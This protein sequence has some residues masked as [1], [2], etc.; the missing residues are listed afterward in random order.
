MSKLSE[1]F[2]IKENPKQIKP[3]YEIKIQMDSN[4]ADYMNDTS[5]ISKER[6][7]KSPDLFFLVLS[8][9]SGDRYSGKFLKDHSYGRHFAKNDHGLCEMI[10]K[11]A[12]DYDLYIY[13]EYGV[14]HSFEDIKIIYF[15]ENSI[16]HDVTIPDIDDMFETADDM[17]NAFKKAFENYEY[18]EELEDFDEE[19]EDMDEEDEEDED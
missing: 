13:D 10:D 17:C 9:I 1:Q 18:V 14:C 2:K 16:K 4:D 15:D 8:Y 3:Y 7:D 5:A 12:E 19:E 11:I 6:W